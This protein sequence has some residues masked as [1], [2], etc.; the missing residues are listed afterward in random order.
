MTLQNH[1]GEVEFPVRARVRYARMLNA[2]RMTPHGGSGKR[3]LLVTASALPFGV[4]GLAL[5]IVV[6]TS[7]E[8]EGG[9]AMPI[10]LFA[11]GMGVGMLV[12]SIVFQQI[13]ARVPRLDQL[14]YVARA[15]IRPVLLEEQQLLAL[16][17]VSDFSFRGW[18]SSLAFQPTWAEMPAELRAKH[19][20]GS[21]GREWAG[22]PMTPL[23]QHRAA[24]DTQFR[25]ASRDDIELFVADALAQGPQ[26]ARFAEVAASE[27]AERMVSR[28]AALT[29][30]SEFE[31]IDLTRPHDGRPPVLLLAGDSERTIGAIR[32]AYMAGYLP[33]D[34]AWALIRQIAARVFATYD[35][36][37]AYWADVAL[38]IAF[39]TDSLDAVQSQQRVRDALL[40]SAWPAATVP[41][42]GAAAPAPR[43]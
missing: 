39:R 8:P 21:T 16:D 2:E 11:L 37:D 15:R 33:A 43:S 17:A 9:P 25:I 1:P 6:A 26:S 10:V 18:N 29:G 30:R 19:A 13:D 28:M 20:D 7:G 5:G 12:A 14:E 40:A 36:W 31:I 41:W 34:D 24:L 27:Q 35:G 3:A 38:A 23:A 4:I 22:L 42:P 32:Y